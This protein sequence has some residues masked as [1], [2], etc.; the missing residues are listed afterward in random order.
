MAL[1]DE[2]KEQREGYAVR[3][4]RALMD[5]AYFDG[6]LADLNIAISALCGGAELALEAP[7]QPVHPDAELRSVPGAEEESRDQFEAS[8]GQT[9]E[10]AVR[11]FSAGDDQSDGVRA[12]P[13]G[14]EESRDHILQTIA[15]LNALD[16]PDRVGQA[17]VEVETPPEIAEDF[18][19][20]DPALLSIDEPILDATILPQ[21][22]PDEVPPTAE[23]I[24]TDDGRKRFALFG[25]Q[26][27][28]VVSGSGN[29][30][31]D[32]WASVL[33]PKPKVDA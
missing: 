32:F 25:G 24:H 21:V 18:T 8:A 19:L 31:A 26:T 15:T 17:G 16:N 1:I 10:A 23:V 4:E 13:G 11:A 27:H 20:L 9:E 6:K 12:L 22:T 3:K 30:D 2:L 14:V 7:A 5:V 29:P 28:E 33:H